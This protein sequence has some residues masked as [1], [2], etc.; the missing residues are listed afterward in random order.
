[1]TVA[2]SRYD[3]PELFRDEAERNWILFCNGWLF[4]KMKQTYSN[5]TQT[6]SRW[7]TY[8]NLKAH[9]KTVS[10]CLNA[11]SSTCGTN[12]AICFAISRSDNLKTDHSK[13]PGGL[14][15]CTRKPDRSVKEL[16]KVCARLRQTQSY[17]AGEYVLLYRPWP[18]HV[19][20][21]RT[22]TA[23]IFRHITSSWNRRDD[24]IVA[25]LYRHLKP[26]GYSHNTGRT[27]SEENAPNWRA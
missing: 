13:V 19:S 1:M 5:S 18:L 10:P 4:H 12:A 25:A 24:E 20:S 7:Q 14:L 16:E 26:S 9:F 11:A 8:S 21:N 23:W 22:R 3:H 17:K 2:A 6:Q 27:H 15:M